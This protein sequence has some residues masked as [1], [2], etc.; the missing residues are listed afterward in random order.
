MPRK[1][2]WNRKYAQHPVFIQNKICS[3]I[4]RTTAVHSTL[5]YVYFIC[6][7]SQNLLCFI[8]M[9][10]RTASMQRC[11]WSGIGSSGPITSTCVLYNLVYVCYIQ[12][13]LH[14]ILHVQIHKRRR[15]VYVLRYTWDA[16]HMGE[17]QD[18]GITRA[19]IPLSSPA[20]Y[21]GPI[22]LRCYFTHIQYTQH[23][24]TL[25][26]VLPSEPYSFSL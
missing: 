6:T 13:A 23:Q 16:Q 20:K 26:L 3:I 15:C 18:M 11:S 17:R 19:L 24:Y 5:Y 25:T 8:S 1:L 22:T 14:H 10:G 21:I 9:R 2:F 4:A 12:C 7:C